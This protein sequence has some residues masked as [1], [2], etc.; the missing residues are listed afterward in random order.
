LSNV[1]TEQ[2]NRTHKP[3]QVDVGAVRFP[4]NPDAPAAHRPKPARHWLG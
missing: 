1:F 3:G 2:P 4:D